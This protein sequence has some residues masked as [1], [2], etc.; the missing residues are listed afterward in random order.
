[1]QP[2]VRGI[3]IAVWEDMDPRSRFPCSEL[4]LQLAHVS[5]DILNLLRVDIV[6]YCESGNHTF[7]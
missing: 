1:L 7:L 3:I 2:R 5:L 6:M 4:N